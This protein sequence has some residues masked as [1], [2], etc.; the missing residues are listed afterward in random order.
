MKLVGLFAECDI[1]RDEVA[2]PAS[3]GARRR[4]A[5]RSVAFQEP[6][7]VATLDVLL[8]GQPWPDVEDPRL[9]GSFL[10]RQGVGMPHVLPNATRD[11]DMQPPSSTPFE[12]VEEHVPFGFMWLRAF[13]S[14]RIESD[15]ASTRVDRAAAGEGARRPP[16]D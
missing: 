6:R 3:D 15:V 11:H 10:P 8:G 5:S 14:M 2:A 1:I 13:A 4:G 7:N 16:F 12:S 9:R